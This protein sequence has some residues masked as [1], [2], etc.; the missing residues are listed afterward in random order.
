MS[1]CSIIL[2]VWGGGSSGGG[3]RW[4]SG[5]LGCQHPTATAT[6]YAHVWLGGTRTT[7]NN[8]KVVGSNFISYGVGFSNH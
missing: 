2:R 7:S 5:V 6:P 8:H 1:T 3:V 4:G